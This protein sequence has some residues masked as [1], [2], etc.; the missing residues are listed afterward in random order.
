MSNLQSCYHFKLDFQKVDQHTGGKWLIHGTKRRKDNQLQSLELPCRKSHKGIYTWH[1]GVQ[2]NM[3]NPI[4]KEN[5]QGRRHPGSYAFAEP[6]L[7]M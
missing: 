5:I 7:L 4:F 6:E 2:R 3:F 1:K